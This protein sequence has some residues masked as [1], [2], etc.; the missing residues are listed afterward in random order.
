MTSIHDQ[1]MNYVYQQVLQ[2][3]L[4]FFSRAERTALQ[5]LIQRLAVAAGGMGRIGEYKV[6]AIQSGTRDNCYTLALL[7]AAQLII[8]TRAPATFQL[9]IASLRLNGASCAA[10]ENM[11]RTNSALFVYDDPRVEVLMVD[12]REVLPF[13]HLTP[14]SDAGRESGR[15]NLLMIGHRRAWRGG[16]DLWDDGYLTTGEFYGQIAR[17]DGGVDALLIADTL[18]QQ[19]QFIDGLKRAATKAGLT[20]SYGG[21]AG[22]SGLFALLDELGSDCYHA[23]YADYGQARWRPQE[24]FETCRRTACIDIHD[25]LVSNL[26]ERWPLL[27]EFLRFQPDELFAQISDNEFVSPSISAHVQGLQASFV[28]GRDYE[29]GVAQ[30]LQRALVMMR[31]KRLPERL[32]EQAIKVFG[33]PA[34]LSELRAR[35]AAEAQKNLGLSEAQLVCLLFAPFIERGAGLERFLRQCHPGMLV[36]MPELH[37]A[38]QGHPVAEQIM[39]WMMDVSGLPISLIGRLYRMEWARGSAGRTPEALIQMAAL[40]NALGDPDA[41]IT[42]VDEWSAGH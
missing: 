30:Y 29:S 6:L 34:T 27:T 22:Y 28:Q 17:W 39:Q 25:L 26:E 40:R 20:H 32:C 31:R 12:D 13:N 33:N 8:A 11:H 18:G 5:L 36:A 23:F 37:R 1:A 16:F 42:L 3:L 9:R 41:D 14:T 38:M 19:K 35:A 15:L 2:R 21:E 10:V 24:R 7:R 4:G